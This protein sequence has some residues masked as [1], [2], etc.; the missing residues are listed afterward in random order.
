MNIYN[1]YITFGTI[2]CLYAQI[3]LY[4]DNCPGYVWYR[5]GGHFNYNHKPALHN[6][7]YHY[8]MIGNDNDYLEIRMAMLSGFF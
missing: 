3:N 7:K 4:Y 1:L 2:P 8:K 6:L 5:S